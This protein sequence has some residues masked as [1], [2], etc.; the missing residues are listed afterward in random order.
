MIEYPINVSVNSKPDHLPPP[1]GKPSWNVFDRAQRKCETP[2]PG[3]EKN[4][5]ETPPQGQ[6]FSKIQQKLTKHD[7][8]IMKNSTEMLIR[9]EILK[10]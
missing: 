8:E 9:L 4:C 1:P 7:T 2:T 3:A 10:Q 6:L 5:A